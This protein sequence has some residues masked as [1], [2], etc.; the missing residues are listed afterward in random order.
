MILN[1]MENECTH[2]EIAERILKHFP[3]KFSR[4]SEAL[5]RIARLSGKYSQ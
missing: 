4:V 1:L 5:T 3:E 2:A